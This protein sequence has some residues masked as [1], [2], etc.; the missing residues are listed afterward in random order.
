MMR[1]DGCGGALGTGTRFAERPYW[2]H[3]ELGSRSVS[4]QRLNRHPASVV[5]VLYV[6]PLLESRLQLQQASPDER[7]AY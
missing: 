6:V 5:C 2:A 7:A 3:F 4:F 1:G